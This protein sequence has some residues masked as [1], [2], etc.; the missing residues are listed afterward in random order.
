MQM[1]MMRSKRLGS[2]PLSVKSPKFKTKD[3]E[4]ELD[5]GRKECQRCVYGLGT[6]V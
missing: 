3:R 6:L 5:L 2:L 4:T 1:M